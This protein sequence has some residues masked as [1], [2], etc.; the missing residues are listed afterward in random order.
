MEE[1]ADIGEGVVERMGW[2]VPVF[3]E[4]RQEELFGM[5]GQVGTFSWAGLGTGATSRCMELLRW[6]LGNQGCASGGQIATEFER[7]FHTLHMRGGDSELRDGDVLECSRG[8][9]DAKGIEAEKYSDLVGYDNSAVTWAQYATRSF[10]R[11]ARR[12]LAHNMVTLLQ[13]LG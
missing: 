7:D 5:K 4:F 11:K 10:G 13:D 8:G 12:R 9:K 6:A 2:L 1:G 3:V